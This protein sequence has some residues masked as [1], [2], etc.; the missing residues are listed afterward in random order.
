MSV[1]CVLLLLTFNWWIPA[2]KYR[3]AE[4]LLGEGEY[5]AAVEVLGGLK[6]GYRHRDTRLYALETLRDIR[7]GN[8]KNITKNIGDLLSAGV[9]VKVTYETAGGTLQSGEQV[10]LV[11]LSDEDHSFGTVGAGEDAVCFYQ[12]RADFTRLETAARDGYELLSWN[13]VSSSMEFSD[14]GDCVAVTLRAVWTTKAYT[15]TFDLGGGTIKQELPAR[16]GLESEN[17]TIG[18]PTRRG[19]TFVGWTGTGLTEPAE[20]ICIPAGSWGDRSYTALWQANTYTLTLDANGGTCEANIIEAEYGT[21]PTIS[22]PIRDGF[23]FGGWYTEISLVNAW[24]GTVFSDLT[25]HAYWSEETKPCD[26]R[27]ETYDNGYQI[28]GYTGSSVVLLLPVYIGGKPVV[29]IADKA[30]E[31]KTFLTGVVI[32][33]SV[34]SIGDSA[35][36]GC[37]GL[38]SVIIS[39]SVT[40]VGD[41][42]FRGCT[43]LT[44][45][46]IPDSLTSVGEGAFYGTAHYVNNDNWENDVLYIG[47]HLIDAR[48]S[49]SGNYQVKSGTRTIASGAFYSC[50]G[51]TSITI[52]SGVTSIGERAFS[53]CKG[54]TSVTIP[55]SVTNIGFYA[56]YD[57][58]S[59]REATLPTTAIFAIPKGNLQTVVI[60]GGTSIGDD[61]FSGCTGLA[62]VTIGNSVTS[63]GERAFSGC[64]G[65]ASVTIGNGVTSIGE[66]AFSGCMR[67][68]AVHITDLAAWCRIRF[69]YLSSNP[70]YYA[71]HLYL[72]GVGV[73]ELTIPG[74][75]TSIGRFAFSG[76]TDL[77]TVTIGSG[78]TSIG[79]LAFF[80]CT[81]LTSV[82]IPSGVTSIEQEAFSGCTGLTSIII[83]DSVTGTEAATFSGCTG[84]TTITIPDSV[85]S[86][87]AETFDGCT[88]L[89]TIRYGGTVAQ[90]KAISK[91]SRWANDTGEFVVYCSDGTITK[92]NA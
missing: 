59:I 70:L 10:R 41:G 53:G 48:Q 62:S 56:F 90:W 61:A 45:I 63:I 81:S 31:N 28:T 46:T 21:R 13:Y 11:A 75:V 85:T 80:G 40:S 33:D 65:L 30:F 3:H 1:I 37:T 26:L 74:G 91:Y 69:S 34:K 15:L 43:R 76:C 25:L 52:P 38:I 8:G 12:K 2:G 83:P 7:A 82:T 50:A 87:A 77:T 6:P 19:Y 66:R 32:P 16:Y 54:L 9:P 47:N 72:N 86:I 55:N 39:E 5:T 51:L 44:S 42:A 88:S 64:T 60:N 36:F 4:K 58:T 49:L 14:E 84:L 23:T 22:A 79:R 35:F 27:Y 17:I 68:T 57:C 92:G 29:A 71:N 24:G 78:V 20:E 67:L 73:T 18:Q 89:T